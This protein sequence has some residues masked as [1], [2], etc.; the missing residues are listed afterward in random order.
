MSS[1]AIALKGY[2][3]KDHCEIRCYHTLLVCVCIYTSNI[4]ASDIF[5]PQESG[6]A[7]ATATVQPESYRMVYAGSNVPHPIQF[8]FSKEGMDHI[9]RN[10]P[11]SNL[12]GLVSV[13]PNASGLEASRCAIILGSGFW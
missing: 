12:D 7:L 2:V 10:R 13:W 6:S 8:R 9:V 3:V 1:R 4:P 11:G 5:F